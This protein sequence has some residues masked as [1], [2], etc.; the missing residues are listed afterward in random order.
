MASKSTASKIKKAASWIVSECAKE[1]IVVMRYDA[2][3]TNSVYLKLDDGVLGS[4]RISDHRGKRHLK[5]KYNL[6]LGSARAVKL[7]GGFTRVYAPFQ[8]IEMLWQRIL[9]DRAKMIE[10]YGTMY[11][12]FMKKNRDNAD[13]SKG[14]WASAKYVQKELFINYEKFPNTLTI[15]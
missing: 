7:D 14:F 5:Y 6:T 13:Y 1:G 9:D 10:R 3:G 2:Y 15:R 4:L 11:E 8:D 12:Q